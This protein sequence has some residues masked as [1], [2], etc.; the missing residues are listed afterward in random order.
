MTAESG[1]VTYAGHAQFH[2]QSWRQCSIF[3]PNRKPET[4]T[5]KKSH[6]LL[7]FLAHCGWLIYRTG[8]NGLTKKKE[9]KNRKRV[10][11][12]TGGRR[13]RPLS[14]MRKSRSREKA[15]VGRYSRSD[16][17]PQVTHS[18]AVHLWPSSIPDGNH[19]VRINPT[20]HMGCDTI[21]VLFF[22]SF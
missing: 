9:N 16:L 21:V 14:K 7:P 22:F 4:K 6:V 1:P 12:D 5:N 3:G 10:G 19:L 8:V 15:S 11:A 17:H 13:G 2:G 20:C 18:P